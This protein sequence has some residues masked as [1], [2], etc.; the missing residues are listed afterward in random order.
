MATERIYK[1]DTAQDIE[2]D[3]NYGEITVETDPLLKFVEVVVSTA[4]DDG[5]SADAVNLTNFREVGPT[6]DVLRVK[7]EFTGSFMVGTSGSTVHLGGTFNGTVIM[8]LHGVSVTQGRVYSD[9]KDLFD[10][11]AQHL[12]TLKHPTAVK[13][14][15]RMP[16][17]RDLTLDTSGADLTANGTYRAVIANSNSGDIEVEN[18]GLLDATTVSGDIKARRIVIDARLKTVSGDIRVPGWEGTRMRANSVSGDV[19]VNAYGAGS[20]GSLSVKTVSGDITLRS[21]RHIY[22]VAVK[23]V[24]GDKHIS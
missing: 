11:N 9:G 24:S 2:I 12:S 22:D 20:E 23:T 17:A 21:S 10:R 7:T 8:G 1:S 5:P 13:I 16:Q 6:G 3:L 14:T 19:N 4:D 18:V 15:V